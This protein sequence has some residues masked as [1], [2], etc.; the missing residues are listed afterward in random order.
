[1]IAQKKLGKRI[2]Q[3]RELKNLTQE[4]FEEISGIN[5]RY[6]SSLERGQKNVTIQILERIA[7]A[8]DIELID[9][10]YFEGKDSRT[11]DIDL[12]SVFKT[13][14]PEEKRKIIKVLQILIS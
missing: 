14:S 10:F 9:L 5:A 8:L 2:K 13:V 1:M 3:L 7:K 11:A 12:N 4:R 6:L